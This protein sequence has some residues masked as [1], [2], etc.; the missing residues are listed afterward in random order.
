MLIFLHFKFFI[1]LNI[2]YEELR[3]IKFR[4]VQPNNSRGLKYK[5]YKK[6]RKL[7]FQNDIINLKKNKISKFDLDYI[8]NIRLLKDYNHMSTPAI[9]III[10]KICRLLIPIC[11]MNTLQVLSSANLCLISLYSQ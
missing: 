8:K 2:Y 4:Y 1:S 3:K 11:Q 6:I 10:N 7:F 5:V 9:G